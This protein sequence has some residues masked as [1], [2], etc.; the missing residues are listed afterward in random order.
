MVNRMWLGFTVTEDAREPD[1]TD[2]AFILST[3]PPISR[4]IKY[5]DPMIPRIRQFRRMAL[6]GGP[7]WFDYPD[8]PFGPRGSKSSAY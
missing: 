8:A 7:L 2:V 4:T 6:Y 3:T 5:R 1:S